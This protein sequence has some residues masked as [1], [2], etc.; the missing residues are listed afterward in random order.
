MIGQCISKCWPQGYDNQF[1][2][3]WINSVFNERHTEFGYSQLLHRYDECDNLFQ[4]IKKT[5]VGKL[6][7]F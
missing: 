6:N 4:I 7:S 5:G 1:L 3:G 2:Q